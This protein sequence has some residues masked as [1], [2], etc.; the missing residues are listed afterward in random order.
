MGNTVTIK[1]QD[2]LDSEYQKSDFKN[3]VIE[4]KTNKKYKLRIHDCVFDEMIFDIINEIFK[5][6]SCDRIRYI[7]HILP[8]TPEN[9]SE[10]H[11]LHLIKCNSMSDGGLLKYLFN[12]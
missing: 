4:C 1:N 6:D 3:A 9:K 10:Y 5:S 7:K 2:Y 12:N 8:R 11:I